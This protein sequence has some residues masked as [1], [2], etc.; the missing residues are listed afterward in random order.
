M[1]ELQYSS[2]QA[3]VAT[4]AH[5]EAAEWHEPVPET[6]NLYLFLALIGGLT[7]VRL[8]GLW[9]SAVDLYF[10]ESQYW[11][12]GQD[13]AFGSFSRLPLIAWT[14]A[15]ANTVCG[16][17]EACI[18]APAPLFYFGMAL[19]VY[20]TTREFY[21]NRAAFWSGLTA[22]LAPGIV[23]SARIMTAD[24]PLLFF[25]SL[26]LLAYV[27]LLR[28]YR[29]WPW[30]VVLGVAFG[31]GILAKYAMIYFLLGVGL[32]AFFDH[33]ALA[34]LRSRVLWLALAG[35]ALFFVPNLIWNLDNGLIAMVETG[36]NIR[37]PGAIF[38]IANA[39]GFL[40]AQ[41]AIGGPIVF[42]AL[43]FMTA[44]FQRDWVTA[45][46]RVML[47]FAVPVFAM[48]TVLAIVSN[49]NA[50]WAA[51][52]FISTFVAVPALLVQ[53]DRAWLVTVS[54]AFGLFCQ[55][56]LFFGDAF[57]DKVSVPFL[58]Q[59][60]VYERTLGWRALGT[61]TAAAAVRTG[62]KSIVGERRRDVASLVYYAR[63][64]GIPI[65]AWPPK[66]APDDHFQLTRPLPA[67]APAPVLAVSACGDA[68]RFESQFETVDPI[69][70][71]KTPTG[72]TT[73]RTYFVFQ[74]DGRLPTP[75]PLKSCRPPDNDE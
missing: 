43:I 37:G 21:G 26:A 16:S 6:D 28:G 33:R 29:W 12:W 46:D 2:P 48:I 4:P 1:A 24:V 61:E 65:Y 58:N 3:S 39:F 14:I 23:Y 31:L 22:A 5:H 71:F 45:A 25:W 10:D 17:S 64:S 35:G 51:P 57:A 59:P 67:D 8:I 42:A 20:L 74:L 47:A 11:S 38:D 68:A 53:L 56:A 54:V 30:A 50:N 19:C 18:R 69:G 52:A 73:S 75:K 62:S 32:A 44:R 49:A 66:G 41:F 60:D 9:L 15:A 40:G 36:G 55:A 63:E 27:K 70:S 34:L 13:L 7:L 72:P